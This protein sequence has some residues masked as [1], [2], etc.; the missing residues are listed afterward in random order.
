MTDSFAGEPAENLYKCTNI[1]V[2]H[3]HIGHTTTANLATHTK[4]RRIRRPRR[5]CH[6]ASSSSHLLEATIPTS[7]AAPRPRLTNGIGP[8]VGLCQQLAARIK[9]RHLRIRRRASEGNYAGLAPI[10][11]KAH[12]TRQEGP[13][14]EVQPRPIF[15]LTHHLCQNCTLGPSTAARPQAFFTEPRLQATP[16]RCPQEG[17]RSRSA[18]I[19]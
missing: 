16:R 9:G 17:K 10:E 18:S 11:N 1:V 3:D 19:A 15:S 4:N 7:I 2:E 13:T 14:T 12:R 5:V 8:H 6:K